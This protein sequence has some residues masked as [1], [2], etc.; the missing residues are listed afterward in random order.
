ML[1]EFSGQRIKLWQR[2]RADIKE[3]NTF[4]ALLDIKD[5]S[6]IGGHITV[7]EAPTTTDGVLSAQAVFV[8][9]PGE[10]LMGRVCDDG[11]KSYIEFD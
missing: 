8:H 11:S 5:K 3:G 4:A 9:M 7:A 2:H 1:E 6:L 10:S